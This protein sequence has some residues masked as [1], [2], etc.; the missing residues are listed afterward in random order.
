MNFISVYDSISFSRLINETIDVHVG[1]SVVDKNS[2]RP[3]AAAG[4]SCFALGWG[5]TSASATDSTQSPFLLQAKVD[6]FSSKFC[7]QLDNERNGYNQVDPDYEFC[8]GNVAGGIDA[9]EGDSGGPLVCSSGAGKPYRLIG[10]TS[11]VAFY[12]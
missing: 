5:A 8:S 11:W 1:A 10:V 4:Q 3:T 7:R 12:Y 6:I 2:E 9:C